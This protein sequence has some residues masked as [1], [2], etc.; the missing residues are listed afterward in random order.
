VWL[1][2]GAVGA[3]LWQLHVADAAGRIVNLDGGAARAAAA[4]VRG[5]ILCLEWRGVRDAKSGAG[6]FDVRVAVA[7]HATAPRLTAWRLGVKN[8]SRSWTIWHVLFPRLAGLKPGAKPATDRF[9]WP[10]MW[11]M[12]ATGWDKMTDVSGPCG[13]YGKHSM[14]FMGFSCGER[15]L[16]VGAHDPE[17]WQKMMFFSPGK[18]TDTPRRASLHFLAHPSG[19]TEAGNSYKQ[20]YDIAVGEVDGDWFDAAKVYAEF[21]RRQPWAS[22]PPRRAF[23]GQREAREVLAWEQASINAFPSDRVTTVNGKPAADWVADMIALRR[24]LGV[25]LAV[26]MYHWH[27]TPFDTNYPDYFPVKAGFPELVADLKQ[28]G[29]VVMPYINGRLWDQAAP[30]YGPEAELNAEKIS[31]QRVNPK[32]LYAWPE[33]YGNGQCLTGMC[34]HT[35][36]WRQTVVNLCRRIV[37]E[38]GCGGVY[39]D[40][41]G[42]FGGRVCLDPRHGHPLGGGA[43]WLAGMRRMLAEIREAIG[44][45]PLLTTE[46]NWEG[47]VADFDALLDTQWNRETNLPIFPAVYGGLGAIYGGDV[48]APAYANGGDLFVQRMGMRFVWGGQFG[49][50]HFEPL[51]KKENRALL[52]FFKMLCR[53][54][55]EHARFFCR[56]EFLRPPEVTLADGTLCTNPLKGPVLAA[57][58]RDPDAPCHTAVFLVNV[59]RAPQ[60]VRLRPHGGEECAVALRPLA[61]TAMLTALT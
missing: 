45:E 5:G 18:A 46:N 4:R 29:V 25:R 31:A 14:Q 12:Q 30:S 54:R 39:L 49:W 7:S 34:L 38:L 3:H 43:Y 35:E 59:T 11:G 27:Q 8:R 10:E 44:P 28:G 36:Y 37:H 53:L 47:C 58:W 48:F 15:T 61:A 2:N 23:H 13:G 21:A 57:R 26:H 1:D 22:R 20:T 32:T 24:K 40:Q 55:A 41:L 17:H 16:Y 6:P 56:G 19:M 60:T 9:F 42:C 33:T 51:L 52:A 50:G